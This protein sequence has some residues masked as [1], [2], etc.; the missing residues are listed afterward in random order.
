MEKTNK[1][2]ATLES[3]WEVI[4]ELSLSIKES[5]AESDRLRKESEARFEREMAASRAEFD[6]RSADIDR[7]IKEVNES[8]NGISK[9]N[10]MLAEEFFFNAIDMGDKKIFGEQFDECYSYVKRHNKSNQLRT[11]QDIILFNG[12]S[13]ALVEVKYRARKEDIQKIIDRLP[14]FRTLYSEYKE[15]RTYLGIAAMS[16]DKGVEKECTDKG[17]AIVKQVGDTVVINDDHLNTF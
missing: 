7:Q 13:I 11:E 15:H 9:S 2:P 4:R 16:F 17:V 3:V 8:V 10:G 5:S 6:R 14:K 1:T 12:K